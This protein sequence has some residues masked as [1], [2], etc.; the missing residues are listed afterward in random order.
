MQRSKEER[1]GLGLPQDEVGSPGL[2]DFPEDLHHQRFGVAICRV[3]S[4]R[5][6]S[7]LYGALGR[8]R[9]IDI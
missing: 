1:L 4:A 6:F 9:D 8:V 3:R 2:V 5:R 7:S